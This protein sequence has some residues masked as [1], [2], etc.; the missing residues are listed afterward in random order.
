MLLP[1]QLRS[2]KQQRACILICNLRARLL[3][4]RG[5]SLLLSE[6]GQPD[7]QTPWGVRFIT[8]H[9]KEK[10][11][12]TLWNSSGASQQAHIEH[13]CWFLSPLWLMGPEAVAFVPVSMGTCTQN[14]LCFTSQPADRA[15]LKMSLDRSSGP[16]GTHLPLGLFPY[17][18]TGFA[19]I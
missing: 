3:N 12:R 19:S 14:E 10:I 8:L 18:D 7:V 2:A 13:Q 6:G 15:H 16:V 1:G 9:S 17:L 5:V 4:I 11:E